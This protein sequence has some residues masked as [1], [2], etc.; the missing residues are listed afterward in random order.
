MYTSPSLNEG[1]QWGAVEGNAVFAI[2]M[3]TGKLCALCK[4]FPNALENERI[5]QRTAFVVMD[6]AMHLCL[7]MQR[8]ST[9]LDFTMSVSV[10]VRPAYLF[11]RIFFYLFL[12]NLVVFFFDI[13]FSVFPSYFYYP[14]LLCF[15]SLFCFGVI[16][17]WSCKSDTLQCP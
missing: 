13:L 12:V 1:M 7:V 17:F 11:F 15:L 2:A 8:L 5:Y 9:S 3:A 14:I 16:V 4:I 10:A 6:C